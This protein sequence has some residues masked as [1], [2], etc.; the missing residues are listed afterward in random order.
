MVTAGA[1]KVCECCGHPIP[2]FNTLRGLTRGQQKLFDALDKAGQRGLS[3]PALMDAVY[4]DDPNGGP[5][6]V[7]TLNVQRAK[8]K[9]VLAEN[10]LKIVTAPNKHWRLEPL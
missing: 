10:G 1:L 6:F 7:N 3:R 4:G 2:R 8:M 5:L 9:D